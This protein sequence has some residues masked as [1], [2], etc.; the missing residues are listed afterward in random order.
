LSDFIRNFAGNRSRQNPPDKGRADFTIEETSI[1]G[2]IHLLGIESPGLTSAPSIA[3]LVRDL[4]DKRI[5]LEKR[6]DFIADRPGFVGT[7]S[8]LPLE[9]RLDLICADPEYGEIICRCEKITKKE[10]RQA[11]ENPLR[12][13]TMSSVKYR[14]RALM[15]RCQGGF[16]TPRIVRMLRDEYGYKPEEFFV[17]GGAPMFSGYVRRAELPLKGGEAR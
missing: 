12:A 3:E 6:N 16:C 1:S 13:R 7:F 4:V 10:I 14:A 5:P 17:R 15:G 8:E 9:Q 11:I 2:F